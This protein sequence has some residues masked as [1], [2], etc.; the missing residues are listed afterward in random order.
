MDIK[1]INVL[2]RCPT[3]IDFTGGFTDV[4]PFRATQWVSHI[5]AAIDLPI[6][7][8]LNV[9]ADRVIHI[10]DCQGGLTQEYPSRKDVEGKY[11]LIKAALDDF[12]VEE[13]LNIMIDSEAPRGAGLGTSGSLSVALTAALTLLKE[14]RLPQKGAEIAV[15]AAEIEYKSGVLGGLQD[16]F[17]ATVGGLNVFGFYKSEYSIK[18]LVFSAKQI[19]G[20]EQ[21]LFIIYPGGKR[22]S[23]DLVTLVMN[24]FRRGKKEV[25]QALTDL[26]LLADDVEKALH[27][28]DLQ[29]LSNLLS[30][31]RGAQLKLDHRL[32]DGNNRRVIKALQHAGING[33][34]LLGGG[35]S[36]ACLLVLCTHASEHKT[37]RSIAQAHRARIIPVHFSRKGMIINNEK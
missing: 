30:R 24:K 14:E 2:V 1:S 15:R 22:N 13:G 26:N 19:K 6:T 28:L 27:K 20:L 34:K 29:E 8:S 4:L 31:V 23:T 21:H 25:E 5:N 12:R 18:P 7:I 11:A 33:I 36:R 10:E 3:R 32:A 9:R 37:V 17:A 35:G 16:Q